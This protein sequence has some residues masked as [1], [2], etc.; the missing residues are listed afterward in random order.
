MAHLA[1]CGGT[2]VRK[3]SFP[4]W[5][6]L[7][8]KEIKAVTEIL[9]KG[10][11]GRVTVFGKGEPSKVD[12]FREAWLRY[13]PGKEY[14]VP[15]SSCCTALELSLRNAGI[16]P[17]DEVITP[18][19][20]WVATNLAPAM[21]GADPVIVD[22]NRDN[23]CI[24]P[25]AIE[26][27]ITPRT[28]AII[29]VHV[30]GYCCEMDRIMPIAERH[31]LVVIEDCAQAHGSKY[32]GKL[33]GNWGHFGCFSF[34]IG[35][36]MTAGEGG[37]V[38]CDDK[39]LGELVYGI[40]GQAGKQIDRILSKNRKTHG[41]NYR[42]TEFQAAIL[43]V[44]LSRMNKHQQKRMKNADYLRKK[45]SEI[46]GIGSVRHEPEQNYYSFIFKYDSNYFKGVSKRKFANALKAEGIP[47]FSSPSDQEP[48]YRSPYFHVPGKNFSKVYCPVAERAFEEE[49]VGI[50]GVNALLG[51]EEDMNDIV[52]AIVK[53]KQSIDELV[54]WGGKPIERAIFQGKP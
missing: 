2:P 38:V 44:Q 19:S 50:L 14:A 40:C 34:D 46:E 1:V 9:E 5:P 26:A 27:A 3:K 52:D 47:M 51:E 33:V 21:V 39:D 18:A 41:W 31:H 7:G 30:G 32:K 22:I 8:D 24:N 6:V 17:G 43:L 13:Y 15:C 25:E 42:M 54:S 4:H 28:A 20:T 45:L 35:K 11:M 29:P 53:I 36:L 37:L 10:K 23:Y 48:V 12:K 16:G 49:A